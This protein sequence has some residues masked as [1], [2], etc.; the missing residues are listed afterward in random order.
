MGQSPSTR[1]EAVDGFIEMCVWE[2]ASYSVPR[3]KLIESK[4]KCGRDL[5]LYF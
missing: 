3:G 4:H 5:W 2:K 1:E